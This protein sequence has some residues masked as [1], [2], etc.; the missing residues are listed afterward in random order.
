M[1]F[2]R[3]ELLSEKKLAGNCMQMSFAANK[4][5]ELWKAFMPKMKRLNLPASAH[6]YSL[7]IYKDPA[8][9]SNFDPNRMFE[10]WAAIEANDL[11][12]LSEDFQTLI[13]PTGLYAVFIHKGPAA[14][15]YKTYEFIFKTWLPQ[16][17]YQLDHRPHFALMGSA[18]KNND[19]DSE[20]EIWIPIQHQN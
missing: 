2:L 1:M 5:A 9:F 16:S 7:E 12:H 10:K 18:Y 19:A 4:T 14:D 11:T 15:G 8:F 13:L 20:E 3:T 17:N 6:L